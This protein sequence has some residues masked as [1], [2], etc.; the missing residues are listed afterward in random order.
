MTLI[1]AEPAPIPSLTPGH[2]TALSRQNPERFM[3]WLSA[4]GP[5]PPKELEQAVISGLIEYALSLTGPNP[6]PTSPARP[7][8]HGM[9]AFV[10]TR[11]AEKPA[12]CHPALPVAEF[13]RKAA[14]HVQFENERDAAVRLL[15]RLAGHGDP[16]PPDAGP[17]EAGA[18]KI[19][20]T[21]SIRGKSSEAAARLYCTF[22]ERN[23]AAPAL[24]T[25]LL[26]R[27]AADYHPGVRLALIR[28]LPHVIAR[29]P[30]MGWA[31][32]RAAYQKPSIQRALWPE[33][34]SIL[35]DLYPSYPGKVRS[36][37]YDYRRPR[38]FSAPFSWS[39]A[40][41]A[42][43]MGGGIPPEGWRWALQ[44]SVQPVWKPVQESLMQHMTHPRERAVA[45]AGLNQLVQLIAQTGENLSLARLTL[46]GLGTECVDV[47]AEIAYTF[48][49]RHPVP[50]SLDT[51]EWFCQWL[52]GFSRV[53]PEAARR[54]G[55]HLRPILGRFKKRGEIPS[56]I[57]GLINRM[58]AWI[59][60]G[61]G[62]GV[63][64]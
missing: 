53:S 1:P 10:L 30:D 24:L 61:K 21:S 43:F 58:A 39:H 35:P 46:H 8:F 44:L 14:S 29:H 49:S 13:L 22:L 56:E 32:L 59:F 55:I 34:E 5:D 25:S 60:N 19:I 31:L 48:L 64:S 50:W 54:I 33:C 16:G 51:L 38:A 20:A 18:M 41:V 23:T 26:F 4:A 11:L 15:V 42:G 40:L 37:L 6:A 36:F 62:N 9:R 52:M 2:L 57:L 7:N 27:F 17:A 45:A 47:A 12:L 63:F 28:V 3:A